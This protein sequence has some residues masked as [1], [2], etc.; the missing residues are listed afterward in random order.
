M[1]DDGRVKLPLVA[2]AAA[3]GRAGGIALSWSWSWWQ[4]RAERVGH[5]TSADT[6]THAHPLLKGVASHPAAPVASRD[7][8]AMEAILREQLA[9]IE[10]M[11]GS[12][13]MARIRGA[14]VVV[15]GLGGGA[16]SCR[17][18]FGVVCSRS[19]GGTFEL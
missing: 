10:A 15:V 8:D 6:K 5:F 14:F 12:E 2:A 1:D 13:G 3:G 17:H 19:D 18:A 7:V 4:G 9:R 11:Y 16:K